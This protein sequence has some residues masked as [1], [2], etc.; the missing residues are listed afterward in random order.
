MHVSTRARKNAC[1]CKTVVHNKQWLHTILKVMF[2]LQLNY[3]PL[4]ACC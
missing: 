1:G 4:V 3:V 2:T